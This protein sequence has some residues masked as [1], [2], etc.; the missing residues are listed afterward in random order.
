MRAAWLGLWLTATG[1]DQA[2]IRSADDFGPFLALSG[3]LDS[4]LLDG[5][6]DPATFRGGVAWLVI[7]DDEMGVQW[8]SA[9]I[10]PR[11]FGY[12]M[13][14]EGPPPLSD[15]QGVGPAPLELRAEGS[16]I[17][18]GLPVMY[19]ETPP[20]LDATALLLWSLG[21][22]GDTSGI[23]GPLP[24]SARAASTGH[25]LAIVDAPRGINVLSEAQGFVNEAPW[26]RW[27]RLEPGLALYRDDGLSCDGWRFV[28]YSQ[29]YQ[30]IDMVDVSGRAEP[31]AE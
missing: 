1:C 18:F 26:C 25:V 13:A 10:E 27:A 28:A 6:E 7:S 17:A 2:L 15:T 29:E 24:H 23:F 16:R 31:P 19:A 22:V 12:A 30:G 4:T 8:Q 21:T 3:R 9:D 11:L 5:D 14:I 20:P